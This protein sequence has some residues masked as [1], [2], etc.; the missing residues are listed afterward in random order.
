MPR[1]TLTDFVDI[2]SKSGTAK[3]TKVA[4]VKNR[5]EYDPKTDFYKK[6]RERI[7]ETHQK[8]EGKQ[9]LR[10]VLGKLQDP[11]KV[12]NYPGI[13]TGYTKWWGKKDLAW[14]KPPSALFANSGIEVSVNPELGLVVNGERHIV[15]LYFKD[16]TLTGARM[17]IATWLMEDCLRPKAGQSE[18]MSILDIR[19]A[20]L[21]TRPAK[22]QLKPVLNAE[23]AYVA[24]LWPNV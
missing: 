15:K 21:I 2:V 19:N 14:F 16:E 22:P 17:D 3:A 11:K 20:R 7:V 6:A 10:D 1:L 4:Q 9:Y 23:L 8:G 13:V 12:S 24:A 18:R 5:S